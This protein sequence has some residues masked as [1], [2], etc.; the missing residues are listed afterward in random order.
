MLMAVLVAMALVRGPHPAW[1]GILAFAYLSPAGF[2]AAAGSW[3]VLQAVQRS[4]ARRERPGA[5]ADFLRGMAAEIDAGASIRQ[6]VAAAADRAPTLQLDGVVRLAEAGRPAPEVAAGLADALPLNGR[7][8][9]AAYQ[10]V[11][12]TG[13]RASAVFAGLA[14]RAAGA[15][16]L[17]RERR[18]L[19]AQTR[20]SAWLV[21]G[22]PVAA[23]A[24]LSLAG[25]GPDPAGAGGP[26]I[27]GG[28]G[29]IAVGGVV[30]WLMVRRS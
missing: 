12:E 28:V 26:L 4:R 25:R 27:A 11:V 2:L 22:L 15:G 18:A 17:A 10:L 21:G 1:A 23:I 20:L 19:T 30:V 8:A 7:L 9:A 3:G 14:V 13:A 24:A 5:E 6:A 29:L 16:D